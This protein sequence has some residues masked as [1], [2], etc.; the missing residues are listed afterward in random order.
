MKLGVIG[1]G[2]MASAIIGGIRK[3]GLYAPEDIHAA[4]KSEDFLIKK[5]QQLGINTTTDNKNAAASDI[6]MLCVKP[7][8]LYDVIEEIK[9]VV[10]EN[11]LIISIAAGQS[12]L[13][14]QN[15][16][17]KNIKLGTCRRGYG[18]DSV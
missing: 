11:T 2:N 18:S 4:D 10:N 13:K 12:L 16:F 17:G 3:S 5:A 6:V 15:A 7:M 8:Y 9:D 1:C 14:M